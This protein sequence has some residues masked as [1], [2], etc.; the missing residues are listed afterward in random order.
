ML[1]AERLEREVLAL[2][3]D[4]ARLKQM[5]ERARTLAVSDAAERIVAVLTEFCR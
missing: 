2:V 5:G 3:S 4:P 1:T